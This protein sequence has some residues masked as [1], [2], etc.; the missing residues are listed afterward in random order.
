M[1]PFKIPSFKFP[2]QNALRPDPPNLLT[3]AYRYGQFLIPPPQSRPL[4]YC[5][6]RR[7][8]KA[9][10]R[11]GDRVRLTIF[12]SDF[13]VANAHLGRIVFAQP[14]IGDLTDLPIVN[15][16]GYRQGYSK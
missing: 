13:H 12:A 2:I 3:R 16:G 11:Y 5:A 10:R 15:R 8:K 1:P 14:V 9:I 4:I 6:G 7:M